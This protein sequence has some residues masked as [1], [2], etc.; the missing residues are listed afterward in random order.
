MKIIEG[1]QYL[2]IKEY[3]EGQGNRDDNLESIGNYSGY[4][5]VELSKDAFLK[6]C[7]FHIPR[8]SK[9]GRRLRDVADMALNLLSASDSYLDDNWDLSKVYKRTTGDIN[10]KKEIELFPLVLRDASE[11]EINHGCDFYI[12]DGN[13]RCLGY[14]MYLLE[15]VEE[16][17]V[18]QHAFIATNK[19]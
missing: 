19:F 18:P 4:F 8:I 10:T 13:H 1:N 12:Q 9:N 17:Y 11:G 3:L 7:F 14:A 2:Q 15:S 6:L 5:K 16:S